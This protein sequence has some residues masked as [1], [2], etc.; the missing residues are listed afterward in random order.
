MSKD[1]D[2][3]RIDADKIFR[4]Y[5]EDQEI[6]NENY[7]INYHSLITENI[8]SNN[9][10]ITQNSLGMITVVTIY[11]LVLLEGSE[12]LNLESFFGIKD[13]S[14]ISNFL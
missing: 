14:V 7:L 10:K 5:K 11:F 4:A 1:L 13:S 9:K 3:I 12:V 2:K 6:N 8:R